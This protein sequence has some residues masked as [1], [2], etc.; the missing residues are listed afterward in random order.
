MFAA[1][2]CQPQSPGETAATDTS[3]SSGGASS[4]TGGGSPT[5]GASTGAPEPGGV[6]L[7]VVPQCGHESPEALMDCIRTARYVAD[8]EFVAAS[9][10]PDSPHWQEVQDRCA[11]ALESAGFAVELD[12][13]ESGVN[14]VG[15]LAGETD[16]LVVLSAHY[17]HIA[18]CPGA[19]D[20]ASGVAGALEVARALAGAAFT[21]TIV[22]TCLDEEEAGLRGSAA[23]AEE[24]STA[25]VAVVFN[26]D[27]VGYASDADDSQ[28]F[29][30][31]LADRFPAL[32][33]EL[34]A[35]DYRGDFVAI[36]TDELAEPVALDLEARAESIGRLAGVMSLTAEEKLDD[37]YSLLAA[38]DHASF[39][40]HGVPALQ[41]FDTG[42]FRNAAYHCTAG[43]DTVDRLDHAFTTDVLRATVATI[44]AAAG[45]V[46]A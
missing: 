19:D 28:A 17:D 8:L 37:A 27:M 11:D 42:V 12:V 22:V 21:R 23:L 38:S 5:T 6:D 35:H 15:T 40:A 30:G 41:I 31:P 25:D 29:P 20:N 26:F 10:P 36:V 43:L 44:A 9:R 14:V 1:L 7:G 46:G 45:L 39:W 2:A 13:Y 32:A 3:G 18:D 33:E 34:V 16:E 24:L 4:G